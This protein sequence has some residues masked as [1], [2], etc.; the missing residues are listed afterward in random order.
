MI[1]SCPFSRFTSTSVGDGVQSPVPA[2]WLSGASEVVL[3]SSGMTALTT[4]SAA[5]LLN[6]FPNEGG[7]ATPATTYRLRV[8]NTN[9]SSL[10]ITPDASVTINGSASVASGGWREWL[11]SFTSPTGTTWTDVGSGTV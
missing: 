10:V 9:G 4:P 7:L 8:L 6:E 1:H 3:A 2:S 5:A 11:V